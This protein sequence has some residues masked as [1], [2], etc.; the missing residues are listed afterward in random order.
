M[1]DEMI[2]ELLLIEV[3]KFPVRPDIGEYRAR[4]TDVENMRAEL[5][6][7]SAFGGHKEVTARGL[8]Y[9]GALLR[10]AAYCYREIQSMYSDSGKDLNRP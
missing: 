1:K 6:F 8:D 10:L 7:A 9:Q 4:I 2:T 3:Q 5:E